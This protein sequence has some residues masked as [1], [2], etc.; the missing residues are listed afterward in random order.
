MADNPERLLEKEYYFDETLG[1]SLDSHAT[2]LKAKYPGV[3]VQIRRDRDG[4][5]IVKTL[6]NIEY[7][8]N[9]EKIEAW[10][11]DEAR[12]ELNKTLEAVMEVLLPQ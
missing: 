7:K 6:Y 1:Q 5:A 12:T 2:E 9:L 8:Y 4:F 11:K 3:T 10:D